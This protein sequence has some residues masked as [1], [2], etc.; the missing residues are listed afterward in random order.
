MAIEDGGHMQGHREIRP[1]KKRPKKS[2]R[3]TARKKSNVPANQLQKK[4]KQN[5]YLGDEKQ[6]EKPL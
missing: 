5:H 6:D 2:T 4:K 1:T 3:E